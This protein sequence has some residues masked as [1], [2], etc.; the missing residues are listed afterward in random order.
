MSQPIQHQTAGNR[1]TCIVDD[2][3]AELAYARADGRLDLR[4][5]RVPDAIGGR[6]IAGD[7]VRAALDYARAEGLGVVPTCSY[8]AS[9]IERHPEYED[10]LA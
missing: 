9:Y 8:V 7:L 6:G 4:H 5:T 3:E 2:H 1:F 10:L